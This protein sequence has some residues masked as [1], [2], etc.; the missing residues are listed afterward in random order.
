[1]R[2]EG[3]AVLK[4]AV[5]NPLDSRLTNGMF[6]LHSEGFLQKCSASVHVLYVSEGGEEGGIERERDCTNTYPQYRHI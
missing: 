2:R 3:P 1:M 4:V 5:S 6:V